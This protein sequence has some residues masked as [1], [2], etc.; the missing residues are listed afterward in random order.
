MGM[1]KKMTLL[2]LATMVNSQSEEGMNNMD[3]TTLVRKG[4]DVDKS[5]RLYKVIT[6][7]KDGKFSMELGWRM[8]K[9]DNRLLNDLRFRDQFM[10][11]ADIVR[12]F[13]DGKIVLIEG[14]L[15]SMYEKPNQIVF[16]GLESPTLL[17]SGPDHAPAG[18]V[19]NFKCHA[20][21]LHLIFPPAEI[22]W[23]VKN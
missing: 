22:V 13:N 19:L 20:P 11:N 12:G 10:F 23:E 5:P 16:P 3:M 21:P 15:S 6:K 2:T 4:S 18:T 8:M 1:L 17:L 14:K 7:D 9:K